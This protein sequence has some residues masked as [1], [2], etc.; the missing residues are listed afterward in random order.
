MELFQ[1]KVAF[2][3]HF[4]QVVHENWEPSNIM[5]VIQGKHPWDT[6]F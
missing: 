4:F 5:N 1:D 2:I 6:I 3:A